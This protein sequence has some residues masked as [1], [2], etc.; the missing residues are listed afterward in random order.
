[1]LKEVEEALRTLKG[2]KSPSVDNIPAELLKHSSPETIKVLTTLCQRIWKTKE[3]L[4]EWTQSMIVPL[5]QKGNQDHATSHL[6]QIQRK[7]SLILAEE[8]AR[9]RARRSTTEQIF[10]VRMITKNIC[11]T[12]KIHNFIKKVYDH[13]WHEGLWPVMRNYNFNKDLIQV[14]QALYANSNSAVLLNNQLG[15]LFRTTVGVHQ[16]C[17]LMQEHD[18]DIRN[19]ETSTSI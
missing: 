1:M 8:E 4:R 18:S 7:S 5:K 3:W 10:N 14:I 13:I 15:E 12:N 2:G 11:F 17:P 9:F 6:E 19:R 16:G